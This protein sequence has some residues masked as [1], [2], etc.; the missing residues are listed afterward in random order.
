MR[1]RLP[2]FL[3]ADSF[4]DFKRRWQKV[5][6]LS[7]VTGIATGLVVAGFE[8]IILEVSLRRLFEQPLW[9]QAVLPGIGLAVAVTILR[10][11]PPGGLSPMTSDAYIQAYHDRHKRLELA[12]V[13]PRLLAGIATLGSGGG[14]G[15]E[16]PSMYAGAGIGA[17][18]QHRFTR[19][20]G[21]DEANVLLVA[22]AAAGVAAIFKAPA[23]GVI[24][25]LEVPFQADLARRALIPALVSSA[26]SYVVFAGISGT[27]PLF[28]VA[29][30]PPFDLRD[31]GGAVILG[32][33]AGLGARG[34][35]RILKASKEL[36]GKGH[37]ALRVVI[38]GLVIALAVVAS[39]A[40]FHQPLGL[41]PGYESVDW[42]VGFERGS[43]LVIALFM[44]R[45]V[46]STAALAGGGTGGLFIPLVVQGTLLGRLVGN[47]VG[48]TSTTFF[49]MLGIAAFLGA[50]YRTPLAGVVFVAESTGRAGYVVPT[51]IAAAVSQI[52]MGRASVS[53]YQRAARAGH[54]ERRFSLPI[55]AAIQTDVYTIPPTATLDE[56]LTYHLI[57]ARRK[58]VPVTDGG[59][60][61]GLMRM[62]ELEAI[63]RER[64][65]ST[66]VG[67]AMASDLPVGRPQWTIKQAVEAMET[68]G[69]DALP[70][71]DDDGNLA[72]IVATSDLIKLDEILDTAEAPE[73]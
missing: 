37:P 61:L 45:G 4:I 70:I 72:G 69:A 56:F 62:E 9:L 65:A 11:F 35:A 41:G 17:S 31:L 60:Y 20:F 15:L 44:I 10:Y 7:F 13:P 12:K 40:L 5:V 43:W 32:L 52:F 24:F 36:S 46:V 28:R 42:A 48:T 57:G 18:L 2:S 22:G 54:L 26:T 8:E 6:L 50:G 73:T 51:L 66:T 21:R 16:G 30:S 19:L 3:S 59:R 63:E 58:S 14:L 55:S 47:L 39:D 34:F 53:T 71:V 38:A 1:N 27:E 67:E 25:A 49:P 33:L 23:T 64:W 29:G 68:A